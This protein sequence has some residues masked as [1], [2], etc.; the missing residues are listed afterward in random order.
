MN[1]HENSGCGIAA[2]SGSGIKLFMIHGQGVD[3]RLLTALDGTLSRPRAFECIYI[4]LPGMGGTEAFS[5]AGGLPEM[6][7]WLQSLIHENAGTEPF[8]LLGHSMGGILAQEMAFRFSDQVL[9]IAQIAPVV[10]PTAEQRTLP[11]QQ[12][13]HYDHELLDSLAPEDAASYREMA[14]VQSPANWELFRSFAL[15]GIRQANLRAMVKLAKRYDLNPLPVERNFELRVPSLILCGELDHVC[16]HVDQREL[17]KMLP[18]SELVVVPDAGHNPFL[19]QPEVCA[20]ALTG[21]MRSAV[22]NCGVEGV[23]L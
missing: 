3:H 7:D 16:G 13:V 6:A 9:A 19:D 20:Q 1:I 5:N 15:P 12:V 10:Y 2:V 18:C 17:M 22:H 4:D 23:Q 14:V 21:W 11:P 8:A